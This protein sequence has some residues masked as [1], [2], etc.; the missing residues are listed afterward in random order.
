[1]KTAQIN[2]IWN[3]QKFLL[4]GSMLVGCLA[5]AAAAQKSA[6]APLANPVVTSTG[7]LLSPGFLSTSGNQIVDSTGRSQRLAC[8][9]Y[10][11]PSKDI[12]GDV[13]GM[14]K[15]GFNCLRFPFDER[16]LS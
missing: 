3:I 14:K 10:N 6:P 15:A 8:V 16:A 7:G 12:V 9:G 11:E 4:L 5:T 2:T 1:M 13:A